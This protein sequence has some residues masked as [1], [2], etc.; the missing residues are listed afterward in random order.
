M[1]SMLAL[2]WFAMM[3]CGGGGGGVQR[4]AEVGFKVFGAMG[5]RDHSGAP[6]QPIFDHWT[7]ARAA[8]V[9]P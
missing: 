7:A 3:P 1:R 4:D 8:P 9:A 5:I 6:R 2:S